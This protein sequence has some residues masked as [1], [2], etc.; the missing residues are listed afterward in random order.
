M[1]LGIG[2]DLC[3]VERMAGA[4]RRYGQPFLDRTFTRA[5]QGLAQGMPHS[6]P[7]YAGR[8]AAKEAFLKALGTG[9][10][11]QVGWTDVEILVSP[12][13]QPVASIPDGPVARLLAER[14]DTAVH[15]SISC[16]ARFAAALVILSSGRAAA[17]DEPV[18]IG[19]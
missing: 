12:S 15:V 18:R 13:G 1:I 14:G 6:G 8:F 2:N 9:V 4:I 19:V 16:D 10:A 17:P 5:E 3:D 11:E 7:F